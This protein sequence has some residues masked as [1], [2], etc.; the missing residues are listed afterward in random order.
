[1]QPSKIDI[2]L[3]PINRFIKNEVSGGLILFLFSILAMIAANSFMSDWY[4]NIWRENFTISLGSH[5]V[6]NDLLHWVNDGLMAVFFFVIGLELK[7]EIIGGELSTMRKA[8]LPI[9]AGLGGMIFPALIFFLFNPS[10]YEAKGWGIPMATDIAFALGI[11]AVLGK[12]VPLSLKI[13]LTAMAIADDI[14]AVLVIA[15]FYTSNI[16][17]YNIFV[18][19]LFLGT[20][21]SLNLLGVR[22]TVVYAII[23]IGGL[24]LA[25]LMSGVHATIAGVLAAMTIPSGK[26]IKNTR[27]LEK[28]KNQIKVFEKIT[29]GTTS[30]I[31]HEQ[32]HVLDE[33]KK[34]IKLVETPL[35]RLEHRMH[36]FV[37]FLV[38]PIFAFANAG[39]KIDGNIIEM[40]TSP[41]TM[42]VMAGLVVGKLLGISLITKLMVKMKIAR[43]P[44]DVNWAQIYGASLLAGVGFTMSLFITKL[45]YND[46]DTILHAKVGILFASLIAGVLGYILLYRAGSKRT[47]I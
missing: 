2:L 12:R 14:G 28:L 40:L 41:I 22:N 36:P 5:E 4:F 9:G 38:I 43:L 44:E 26:K 32:L 7:R 8:I 47:H 6:T 27:F 1:M 19:A 31:S 25:F 37:V 35:Q 30:L 15:F 39:V 18:G 46:A 13:F 17:F 24:W 20:M 10:G 29:P 21:I 16:D 11:M 42:G 34:S 3:T 33:I 23:G 45:A